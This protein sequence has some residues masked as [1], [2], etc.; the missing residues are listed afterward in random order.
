MIVPTPKARCST[1]GTLF[2]GIDR[3][4]PELR[5]PNA[6]SDQIIDLPPGSNLFAI[7]T[8]KPAGRRNSNGQ[9]VGLPPSERRTDKGGVGLARSSS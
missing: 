8:A 5:E 1:S 2:R 6:K 4:A 9:S 3:E 7:D